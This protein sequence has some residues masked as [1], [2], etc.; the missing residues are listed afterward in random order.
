MA[1]RKH[2][3][4]ELGVGA[5]ADEDQVGEEASELVGEAEKHGRESCPIYPTI[6][7]QD[8]L[9]RP[10]R[11]TCCRLKWRQFKLTL[12]GLP[13]TWSRAL[14]NVAHH[15]KPMNQVPM[16]QMVE[17]MLARLAR[18]LPAG[19]GWAFEHKWDLC[20]CRHKSHYAERRIMPSCWSSSGPTSWQVPPCQ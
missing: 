19:E 17:P 15:L 5:G 8:R 7:G 4:A 18:E 12:G 14:G 11:F 13:H 2:L 6:R 10:C 1:Q 16:P 9:A 20:R 3:G